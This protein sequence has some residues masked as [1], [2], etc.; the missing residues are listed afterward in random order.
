MQT[1]HLNKLAAAAL[2]YSAAVFSA[3][4][5]V[6]SSGKTFEEAKRNGFR[7]AIERATGVLTISEQEV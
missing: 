4:D 1:N 2:F 3:E 7:S 6:E 5:N